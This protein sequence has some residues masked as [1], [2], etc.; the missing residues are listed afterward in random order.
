METLEKT[1]APSILQGVYD[2][3]KL[4]IPA[5]N[6]ELESYS[7]ASTLYEHP[8]NERTLAGLSAFVES[9]LESGAEIE[10]IDRA[11][12]DSLVAWID[13]K[14]SAQLDAIVHA[15]EFQALES[16]WRSLHFLVNRTDFRK[17]VKI[18]LLNAAKESL[19]EDFEDSPEVLQSGLYRHIYSDEYD[20]P[21]GEPYT[22]IISNYEFNNSAADIGLLQNLSQVCAASHCLLIGS[23]G[24]PFFGKSEIGDLP[25]IE[26]LENYME[27]AEFIKW[28]A[29]RKTEDA[30]YVGLVLPRFLLRLPYGEE[31]ASKGF[32]YTESVGASH[33]DYL[34]G[35]AT[36]AFAANMVRSFIDNG[37]CV[38]IRGPESG[39]RV[40]DLPIHYFDAGRGSQMKI[41]TEILIPET[42]EF[43]FSKQGF[44][45]LS[46]Y[47]NRNYG[48][49]FS[50]SSVQ[51]PE[52]YQDES[53]TANARVNARLPY[54][55]LTAR[56]AHYLKVLQRENIGACKSASV[57]EGELNSW[58][59]GL[60][61]EMQNPGPELAA[62]H[63]LS[64]GSVTVS[65]NPENPGFFRVALSVTPHFQV[66]GIDVN[67]SLVSKMPQAKNG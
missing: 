8:Q 44:I 65:E 34:W 28:R 37:W 35:N 24:A 62:T 57:L 5:G 7:D 42:R 33:S 50:A 31:G 43:E 17:N 3:M 19:A 54:I 58:L 41:P 13:R 55:F 10:K 20:T 2:T 66:E 14:I 30:R 61:T 25:K 21:G 47:K 36:F 39:G 4:Q 22:A 64:Q 45:P 11:L 38:Q 46:F 32:R 16:A 26:D 48:C 40:D 29:F 15:S 59:K 9:V 23:V 56:L 18:E 51:L 6:F 1:E 60:V 53:A 27:R 12:I 49:F 63:P 52:E 67:L